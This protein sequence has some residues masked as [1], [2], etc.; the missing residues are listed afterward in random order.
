MGVV[1]FFGLIYARSES[2]D[3]VRPI[4]WCGFMPL[5]VLALFVAQKRLWRRP[6]IALRSHR[7]DADVAEAE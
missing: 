6:A 3:I 1:L 5:A 2:T 7:Q 4:V